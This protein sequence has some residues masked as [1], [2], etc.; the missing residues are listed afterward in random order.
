[1][2]ESGKA[3]SAANATQRRRRISPFAIEPQLQIPV[4]T[5]EWTIPKSTD[6]LEDD[7]ESLDIWTK[8][9]KEEHALLQ[10]ALVHLDMPDISDSQRS[11]VC[12]LLEQ[13]PD[14][15]T[16]LNNRLG[17][18]TGPLYRV[19]TGTHPPVYVRQFP[20]PHKWEVELGKLIAKML[21]EG[22]ISERPTDAPPGW[23]IP[24]FVVPKPDG[25]G[26][27]VADFRL[28]N[29]VIDRFVWP[30]P[31]TIHTINRIRGATW[32]S[33]I[34]LHSGY[35]QVV[36]DPDDRFKLSF[37]ANGKAYIYNRLPMG[38]ID[39]PSFFCYVMH[40]AL[41]DLV[42]K[43]VVIYI[44]DILIYSNTFDE[45]LRLVEAV[46]TRLRA[47]GLTLSKSKCRWFR[48]SIEFLGH[49]IDATGVRTNPKKVEAI[50]QFPRPENRTQLR[51]FLG[52]LNFYHRFLEGMAAKAI[53][54]FNLLSTKIS[55]VWGED[56]QQSFQDLKDALT[57]AP[58]LKAPDWHL[59]FCL[60]VDASISGIGGT[61]TQSDSDDPQLNHVIEFASY[62]LSPAETRYAPTYLEARAI[63][64][65]VK[66]WRHYLMGHRCYVYTDHQALISLFSN[67]LPE[68]A[69]LARWLTVLSE[70]DLVFIYREGKVQE[71]VDA[72]SRVHAVETP[73]GRRPT[74]VCLV[75]EEG[76]TG[77]VTDEP[78]PDETNPLHPIEDDEDTELVQNV[79]G[80]SEDA[81]TALSV[82]LSTAQSTDPL[83]RALIK[84]I[85]IGTQPNDLT[86]RRRIKELSK[87]CELNDDNLIVYIPTAAHPKERVYAP[88]MARPVII[89]YHH[90]DGLTG[91]FAAGRTTARIAERYWWPG[92]ETDVRTFVEGCLSC[93]L[94][95]RRKVIPGINMIP[96]SSIPVGPLF[97]R[98]SVDVLGPLPCT[99]TNKK[100]IVVFVEYL[101]RW[102]EAFAIEKADAS[103][104]AQLI[105]EEIVPRFGP[106]EILLSDRGS[107][108]LSQLVTT[109]TASL[110]IVQ[111]NTTAYHP[112]ANGLV[113][114]MNGTIARLLRRV[115]AT[116]ANH[117]TWDKF[118]PMIL[119]A[120]RITPNSTTRH[121]PYEL[122]YGRAPLLPVDLA[123][124]PSI[125]TRETRPV[126]EWLK[127]IDM[128]RSLAL[129]AFQAVADER[130][131]VQD[132]TSWYTPEAEERVWLYQP[133]T[134]SA[135]AKST[136]RKLHN[137][138]SGPW[139]VKTSKDARN[140]IEIE[141]IKKHVRRT[142]HVSRIKPFKGSQPSAMTLP[143]DLRLWQ[144]EGEVDEE[145][146]EKGV[147]D[148]DTPGPIAGTN[149]HFEVEAIVDHVVKGRW[150]RYK[151]KWRGYELEDDAPL[152]H[153]ALRAPE[154]KRLLE[155]YMKAKDIRSHCVERDQE[156]HARNKYIPMRK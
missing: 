33:C 116:K 78:E 40:T 70:Y 61:L 39:A 69:Q 89:K 71:H 124:D 134:L 11:K 5:Q 148:V 3:Y 114:R 115:L 126:S 28:V 26:R 75:T 129:N 102:P 104:I 60:Y 30:V 140:N 19:N 31:N 13:F 152:P 146:L 133:L 76:T 12:G 65:C 23:N 82:T 10:E 18:Y 55:F 111:D 64:W 48:R 25:S 81:P 91:H 83:S 46:M 112:Q 147:E 63:V 143:E 58:V 144:V 113:E 56:A 34:D 54:L 36:V 73:E 120:I 128:L 47:Y 62:K 98:M 67:R 52:S 86:L 145:P 9:R 43:G 20:I 93:Q 85:K 59:P 149:D 119:F 57:D 109:L 37:M 27:P 45:H 88:P 121:T 92:I 142:V 101:S 22:T 100:Y 125:T 96:P 87:V 153:Q 6:V 80:E 123:L 132:D 21:Q 136:S 66:H 24:F 110:R 141:D 53:P 44:D 150:Y 138:W 151:V 117:Q 155:K 156:L 41:G 72:L 50:T 17:E 16:P 137:P 97:H 103:T 35:H 135:Q 122:L 1:V 118:L 15:Y 130:R 84:Y 4:A 107:V 74:T 95:N 32:F 139:K 2:N 68:Q 99:T 106:P 7:D 14:V 105:T 94:E 42:F 131:A 79:T 154:V 90:G 8:L 108:F 51:R 127:H 77:E 49:V 38:I 29:R